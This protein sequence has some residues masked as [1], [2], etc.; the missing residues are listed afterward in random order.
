MI[1]I[2]LRRGNSDTPRETRDEHTQRKDHGKR[3]QEGG[4]LQAKERPQRKPTL[5]AP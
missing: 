5:L 1:D 3:Q 2:L 4:H